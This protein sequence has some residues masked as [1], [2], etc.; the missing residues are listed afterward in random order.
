MTLKVKEPESNKTWNKN[1]SYTKL[2]R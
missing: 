2:G 1:L